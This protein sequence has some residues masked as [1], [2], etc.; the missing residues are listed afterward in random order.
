MDWVSWHRLATNKAKDLF[1]KM[2]NTSITVKYFQ[3]L[4]KFAS[5]TFSGRNTCAPLTAVRKF[6]NWKDTLYWRTCQANACY[7][8]VG[9]KHC[10]RGVCR[11]R[12]DEVFCD[13]IGDDWK[14]TL[15][16]FELKPSEWKTMM[17]DFVKKAHV[18]LRI[19]Y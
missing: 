9:W 8:D 18:F 11:T 10:S 14:M 19:C 5:T 17:E 1:F 12:W 4:L 13:C 16:Q 3:R 2:N 7:T 6:A 15:A